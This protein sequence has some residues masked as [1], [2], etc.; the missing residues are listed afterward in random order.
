MNIRQ[1]EKDQHSMLAIRN[2]AP[3]DQAAIEH[4]HVF[5]IQ[6][7]GA[8]LGRGPWDNDINAI[9]EYYLNNQGAFLVGEYEGLLVAMGA[10]KRTSPTRAELKRMRIHP[11]YQRCGFGQQIL[12]KLE[13]RA[14]ELGYTTLHLDTS[15]VQ[16]AAQK[17]YEKNG[18]REV[19]REPLRHLEVIFYEKELQERQRL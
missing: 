16:I 5:A 8:Y 6:Q 18:F 10:L 7:I 12:D 17:L 13:A 1:V 14:R 15:T 2:Y 11:D 9:E 3:S 19:G 4:L